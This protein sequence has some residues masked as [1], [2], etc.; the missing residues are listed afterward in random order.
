MATAFTHPRRLAI[1]QAL[2]SGPMRK[3]TLRVK[4]R[5]SHDAL[6]RHVRKL[7]AR[8]FVTS[9]FTTC[10][11]ATPSSAFGRVLLRLALKED[12]GT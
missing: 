1:A 4:T 9:D 6:M 7:E 5:M 8:G 2:R 3:V 10:A 12:L 11:L